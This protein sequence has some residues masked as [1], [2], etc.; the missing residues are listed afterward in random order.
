MSTKKVQG[1][2]FKVQELGFKG[3]GLSQ[4]RTAEPQNLEYRMSKG[5]C[6]ALYH[7]LKK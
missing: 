2:E 1:S 6:A 7:I 5:G 3:S 4:K